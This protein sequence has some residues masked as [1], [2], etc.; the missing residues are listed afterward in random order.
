MEAWATENGYQKVDG[1]EL[2]SEG[3][4]DWSMMTNTD[5]PA[6]TTIMFIPSNLVLSSDAIVKEYGGN[7]DLEITENALKQMERDLAKRL[8]LFRLLVKIL[9]EYEKG[10]SSFWAPWINSLPTQY[11][12]GVS[13]T[14]ACFAC[15]PPYAV[16][17]SMN[18]RNA[19]SRFLN[20]IR[21]EFLSLNPDVINDDSVM[22]FAYNVALTRFHEVFE[23]TRQKLIAPMADMI[24][25]SAEP[26]SEISFDTENN[27]Y[28]TAITDVYAGSPLSVSLG[29][30]TDPTPIF[31]KY[32]FLPTGCNTIFCKAI[33]LETQINELGYEFNQLLFQSDTGEVYPAVW[34]IFLL[35]IL[36]DYDA[37]LASQFTM[38]CHNNDEATKE[39]FHNN[40]FAYTLE[41][42][43]EHVYSILNDVDQM[44]MMAQSYDLET[45]PRVPVIVAHNDLVR[46]TF[47]MTASLLDSMG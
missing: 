2:Y 10:E 12:N 35:K 32:G 38:A 46:S 44:T 6:G 37:D 19:Y 8:P 14:D 1:V 34:D 18:E 17:L 41:A 21:K 43:R 26:N 29:D 23:P 13:M 42:L 28:V 36:Q 3:D 11:Y 22:K 4:D 45:H 31:A 39:T 16:L 25:H 15:L 24:N 47:S 40:Y 5:I 7:F 33:H 30:P 9:A 27:C 20:A